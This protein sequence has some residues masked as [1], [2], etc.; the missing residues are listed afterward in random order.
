MCPSMR[1]LLLA[2]FA[3]VHQC[4]IQDKLTN[5]N[6]ATLT[7]IFAFVGAYTSETTIPGTVV[8]MANNIVPTTEGQ[9]MVGFAP[10]QAPVTFQK[11]STFVYPDARRD[12]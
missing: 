3:D 10:V 9:Y 2:A 1:S 11:V 4:G 12:R 6:G 7:R 5:P 8:R